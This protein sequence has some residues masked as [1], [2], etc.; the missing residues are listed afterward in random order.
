VQEEDLTGFAAICAQ[1]EFDHLDG[2]VTLTACRPMPARRR[3]AA[4][5]A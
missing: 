2:I 3:E 4:Y 5:A 1:H